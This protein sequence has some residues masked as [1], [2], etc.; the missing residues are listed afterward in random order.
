MKAKDTVMDAGKALEALDNQFIPKEAYDYW[1]EKTERLLLAQAEISFKAGREDVVNWIKEN[2]WDG[3]LQHW[4]EGN[5]DVQ[6]FAPKDLQA[7]LKEWD[8]EE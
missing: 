1:W 3:S 4:G 5:Y 2:S 8:I 6:C 7:K